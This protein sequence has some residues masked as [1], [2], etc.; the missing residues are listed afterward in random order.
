MIA[1]GYAQLAADC[2]DLAHEIGEFNTSPSQSSLD[3]ARQAWLAAN[4]S[5]ESPPSADM[6]DIGDADAESD[7]LN[8]SAYS[9]RR[10]S[11]YEP[12][13]VICGNHAERAA[14]TLERD[15]DLQALSD[16]PEPISD[17]LR[18][19]LEKDPARRLPSLSVAIELIDMV[20]AVR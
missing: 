1:P 2:R 18:Q 17:L 4:G 12:L 19:S 15:P 9:E 8:R 16:L 3:R 14:A 5:C 11:T 13:T 7:I 10:V 6:P 20:C